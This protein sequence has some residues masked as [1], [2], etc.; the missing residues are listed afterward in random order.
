M[1]SVARLGLQA[2]YLPSPFST[3][4]FAFTTL[5]G[6]F[7]VVVVFGFC[8]FVVFFGSKQTMHAISHLIRQAAEIVLTWSVLSAHREV[9]CFVWDYRTL[10][11][12]SSLGAA[13]RSLTLLFRIYPTGMFA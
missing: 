12:K 1:R 13:R 4:P 10:H 2:S 8:L 9:S 7:V 5:L 6:F 11:T 3:H